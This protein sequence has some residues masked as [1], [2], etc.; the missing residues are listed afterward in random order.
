MYNEII[1]SN[2]DC[3]Y[4]FTVMIDGLELVE[5]MA[6]QILNEIEAI[7]YKRYDSIIDRENA[8]K[9]FA[10]KLNCKRLIYCCDGGIEIYEP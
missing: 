9:E 3:M 10:K 6:R 7:D 5:E 8:Y 1:I 4:S 2:Y